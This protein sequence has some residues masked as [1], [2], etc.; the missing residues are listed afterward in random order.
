MEILEI[1]VSKVD[2]EGDF[3]GSFF[4]VLL[5]RERFKTILDPKAFLYINIL[6]A[7]VSNPEFKIKFFHLPNSPFLP[8][9]LHKIKGSTLDTQSP[10]GLFVRISLLGQSAG[11]FH[12]EMEVKKIF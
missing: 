1:I 3:I 6:E 2:V 8:Q 5:A 7:L 9:N 4:E 10:F 12:Q 11:Y